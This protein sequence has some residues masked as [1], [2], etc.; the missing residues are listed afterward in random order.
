MRGS[1]APAR[2]PRAGGPSP[3]AS[4][5]PSPA[6]PQ[7]ALAQRAAGL[8]GLRERLQVAGTGARSCGSSA[9]HTGVLAAALG[10]DCHRGTVLTE[11]PSFGARSWGP[12]LV[13]VANRAAWWHPILLTCVTF[14]LLVPGSAWHGGAA[15]HV[16]P[17]G[18][19][20]YS[21]ENCLHPLRRGP[22][23]LFWFLNTVFSF[24]VAGDIQYAM[25]SRRAA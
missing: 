16:R 24:S 11:R 25:S 6:L 13:N 5:Q 3:T 10:C 21:H 19:G 20:Q 22:W 15:P 14:V 9:P 8:T 1:G 2:E 23:W 18:R 7:A 4:P 17:C 12:V